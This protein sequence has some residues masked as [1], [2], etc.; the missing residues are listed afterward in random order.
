MK[1]TCL[2]ILLLATSAVA[3]R[4]GVNPNGHGR[5]TR[6]VQGNNRALKTGNKNMVM[7]KAVK[8]MKD[9]DAKD[10][11]AVKDMKGMGMKDKDAKHAKGVKDM[12]GMGMKDKD[13]KDAKGVKGMKGMGMKD[14]DAKGVKDMKGMGMKDKDA[15]GCQSLKIKAPYSEVEAGFG[16]TAVGETLTFPVYDYYT[17]E[18]IGTYTDATTDILVGGE[19]VDCTFAGSFN[20]DFD[21]SLEFPFVSQV[22]VAGTCLGAS[23]SIAGGTGKYACA[24]GS[25]IFIDGGEDYFASNLSICNTCA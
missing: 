17:N 20:F 23:N 8:G 1:V 19:F 24:S 10:A 25:E 2:S 11:K 15:K 5:R 7:I 16:Q 21:A 9:K 14:K 22:V 3:Y 12:K 13:A 6:G 4:N 18:P